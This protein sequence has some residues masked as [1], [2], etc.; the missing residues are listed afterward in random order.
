MEVVKVIFRKEG[1][2]GS[3]IAVFPEDIEGPGL[4]GCYAHVGQHSST[5]YS[6]YLSTKKATEEEYTPLLNELKN[7]PGYKDCTF[8]IYKKFTKARR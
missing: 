5:H 6:Y 2:E 1:K 3:I 8:K 7:Y 4:Y